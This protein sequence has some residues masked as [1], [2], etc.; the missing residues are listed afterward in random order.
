M[1]PF[2]TSL[3]AV[4]PIFLMMMLGF[5]LKKWDIVNEHFI[6]QATK[7][8]FRISLP[9]LV[10]M[11]I[12]SIDL[13]EQ[14]DLNLAY[15]MLFSGVG[16]FL[17]FLSAGILGKFLQ[18]SYDKKNQGSLSERG[19]FLGSFVQGAFRGNYLIVGYPIL[20][21]LYGDSIVVD[22]ALVTLVVIPCFNIFSI[23]ALTPPSNTSTKNSYFDMI[24]SIFKNP[25][26]IGIL[27]G[28]VSAYLSLNYP[29]FLDSFITMTAD[30]STPLA[31]LAI[32]GFFHFDGL[33]STFKHASIATFFKL[34]LLPMFFT[35]IAY[36]LGF[37][38]SDLM[39]ILVLFGGPTAVSSFAM[40]T[41]MGG[42]NV[43]SGNIVIMTSGLCVLSYV[44]T[45]T[46]WLS[47]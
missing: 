13:A 47:L 15:V 21:N 6:S 40:S 45:M 42:D 36:F 32:G 8:V 7:F 23:I 16:I 29:P 41:E 1:S 5:G 12:S 26:I 31:L 11:K 3:N 43:L 4:T 28:F 2:F 19:Y 46:F 22:M 35:T 44:L 27:L 20:L 38:G 14:I 34:I 24:V 37:R 33:K 25:L 9:A 18:R 17:S 39:I 10:F 30:L